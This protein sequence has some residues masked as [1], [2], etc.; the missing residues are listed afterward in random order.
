M[1]RKMIVRKD[2]GSTQSL[3]ETVAKNEEELQE[4]VKDNPDI[5]P[6]EEFG[7]TGPLMV[8]GRETTLPSGA[9]DLVALARGGDLLIVEFKTGPQNTDFRRALAQLLD[10]G[11]DLWGMS[12]EDFEATVASRY[13]TSQHCRD[14]RVREKSSIEEAAKE[15]WERFTEE[16]SESFRDRL[17]KQLADGAFHYVLVAQRFVRTVAKTIE[18]LNA[19]RSSA[20]FYA[21]ELVPFTG[22]GLYA[23]ESRA[24]V[25]PPPPPP[26]GPVDKERF[27]AQVQDEN[28]RDALRELFEVSHRL[29][30]HFF[31]GAVGAS[32][33]VPTS[34]RPEPLTIA[35]VFPP[36]RAGFQGLTDLT[37]GFDPSSAG[38]TPSAKAALE[39]Y[40]RSIESLPGA[41]DA[42]PQGLRAYRL[43]P[44]VTVRL[45]NEIKEILAEVV[46]AVNAADQQQ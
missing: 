9:V 3:E 20:R 35:W 27:L 34:D 26:P 16:E 25:L 31:W 17:S 43:S 32:I 11:A 39:A 28:Y 33:R 14:K 23:Y 12:Y 8:V 5:L 44:E 42:K 36:G 15:I 30:L 13:F 2:D 1:P 7:M 40:I 24:L 22:E 29:G 41:E 46:R 6:V 4:L 19:I 21:V 38:A 18:Y 37:M 10:Y 45:K